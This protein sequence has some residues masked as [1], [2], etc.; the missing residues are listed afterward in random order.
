MKTKIRNISDNL[1][2]TYDITVGTNH[3]QCAEPPNNIIKCADYNRRPIQ[4]CTSFY[5]MKL[6]NISSALIISRR[7]FSFI[8]G[9]R[10]SDPIDYLLCNQCEVNFS[11]KD[12]DKTNR[13]QFV[14]PDFYW[15][16]LR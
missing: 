2:D 9:Y 11:D 14:W 1:K 10:Y 15:I 3:P 8:K 16:I 12:T 4:N 13:P 5:Q 7:P 6:C